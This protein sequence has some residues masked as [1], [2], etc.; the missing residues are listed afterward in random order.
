MKK[1]LLLAL[2]T[3]ITISGLYTTTKAK[4]QNRPHPLLKS[5][6]FHGK[7]RCA[8]CIAVGDYAKEVVDQEFT[9]QKKAGLVKFKE[10]D[11]S[12]QKEKKLRI[13]IRL[14]GRPYMSTN[15]KTVRTKNRLDQFHFEN[16]REDT[17]PTK[18]N[19]GTDNITTQI[20]YDTVFTR[21]A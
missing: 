21:T 14:H 1:T 17:P 6:I 8:T 9:N 7:Q 20:I 11:I 10:I 5:Y 3:I 15:G 2:T 18:K 19:T 16:A 13:D 12:T 4:R